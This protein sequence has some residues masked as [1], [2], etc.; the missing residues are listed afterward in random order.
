MF[1]AF[2]LVRRVAFL[3]SAVA[4]AAWLMWGFGWSE[5]WTSSW[6]RAKASPTDRMLQELAAR[7]AKSAQVLQDLRAHSDPQALDA[8]LAAEE[9]RG[10]MENIRR[11][12][13]S[14]KPGGKPPALRL[15][16]LALN[17]K[18]NIDHGQREG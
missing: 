13:Q 6:D 1:A 18:L 9:R 2:G 12:T 8:V 5:R 3:G 11:L 17:A 16:E 14:A 4:L 15:A 10:G 7:D